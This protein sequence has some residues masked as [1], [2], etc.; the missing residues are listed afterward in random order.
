ME[1]T[2]F[3]TDEHKRVVYRRSPVECNRRASAGE[4]KTYRL[5]PPHL[6]LPLDYRSLDIVD[7]RVQRYRTWGVP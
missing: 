4:A 1:L 5:T 3:G 7:F 2:L 6:Q